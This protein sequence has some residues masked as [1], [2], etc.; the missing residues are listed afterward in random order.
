MIPSLLV[1]GLAVNTT[2]APVYSQIVL[3]FG[4]PFALVP[5]VLV[6]SRR[7]VMGDMVNRMLTTRLMWLVTGIITALNI[8]LLATLV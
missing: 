2:N 3:S 7:K 4:I 5:L 8:Y 1:L 6:S